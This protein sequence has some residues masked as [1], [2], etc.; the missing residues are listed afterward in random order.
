MRPTEHKGF[1]ITTR[2]EPDGR[3]RGVIRKADGST[4]FVTLPGKHKPRNSL[5]TDPPVYNEKAAI[6]EAIKAIDGGN[7]R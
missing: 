3:W 2:R 7:I 1:V 6:T 4:L 5:E